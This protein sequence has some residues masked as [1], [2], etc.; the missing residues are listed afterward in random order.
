MG[1]GEINMLR[2]INKKLLFIILGVVLIVSGAVYLLIVRKPREPLVV[3]RTIPNEGVYYNPFLP[4]TFYFNRQPKEGEVNFD[5][6][7]ST[8]VRVVPSDSNSIQIEPLTNFDSE[9]DY[10]ITVNTE[11]EY[12][13]TFK[14]EQTVSNTPGWNER[15]DKAFELYLEEHQEQDEGLAYLRKN[16]P[17]KQ[18]N[19]SIDYS[20][21]NN[22]YTV[23]LSPPHEQSKDEFISWIYEKG[24]KDLST[25]RIDYVYQ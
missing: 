9:A 1:S 16:S 15:F 6:S 17:I 25:V 4:V 22:T 13:L 14:T 24:V 8:E 5:I 23:T 19:F 10:S 18:P 3:I 7:P 20:Y 21:A 11:P 2:K 12:T